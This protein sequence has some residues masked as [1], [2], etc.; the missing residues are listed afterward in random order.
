MYNPNEITNFFIIYNWLLAPELI[1][2]VSNDA[3]FR[4]VSNYT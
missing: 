4:G 1:M 3:G 2:T